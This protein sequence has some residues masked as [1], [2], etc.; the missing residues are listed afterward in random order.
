M[1]RI[2]EHRKQ[3]KLN[4]D[5]CSDKTFVKKA[6]IILDLAYILQQYDRRIKFKKSTFY[7]RNRKSQINTL[8]FDGNFNKHID[9]TNFICLKKVIIKNIRHLSL[10]KF[11]NI[12]LKSLKLYNIEKLELKNLLNIEEICLKNVDL[13]FKFL[14]ILLQNKNLRILSCINVNVITNNN[15]FAPL[16]NLEISSNSEEFVENFECISD[17]EEVQNVYNLDFFDYEVT[18]MFDK[19]NIKKLC[20]LNTN[21]KFDSVFCSTIFTRLVSFKY[22]RD[23]RYF[24]I[25]YG[26]GLYTYFKSNIYRDINLENIQ[27][28]SVD[29]SNMFKYFSISQNIISLKLNNF[30]VDDNL[31]NSLKTHC[32]NCLE[33]SFINCIFSNLSFYKFLDFFGSKI[34]Y[35]N[36]IDS[37]LPLDSLEI[38]KKYTQHCKIIFRDR[39][40]LK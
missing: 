31:I 1:R 20:L 27:L 13:D 8:F 37:T 38:L 4:D 34:R 3:I 19:T 30:N 32:R 9:F 15:K 16:Q 24:F 39:C 7:N 2:N 10:D 25:N 14:K 17:L 5:F 29:S 12:K 40:A 28:L 33:F 18:N 36:L 21:I 23:T 35:L 22:L 26:I 11:S 6:Y